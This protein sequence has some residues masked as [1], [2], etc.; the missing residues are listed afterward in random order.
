ML[1]RWYPVTYMLILAGLLMTPAIVNAE[2]AQDFRQQ[3][4]L[5]VYDPPVWF[6]EGYFIA[7]EK[8]PG[9]VFGP[10]QDFVRTLKGTTTW[11]I[12]DLEL[13]RL[14]QAS[15]DGKKV[16]YTVFLEAVSPEGT[17]Y[18]VFVALPH[19]SAQAW[20]DAR[21]AFH[22]GKAVGY[23]GETRKKLE[24]A[25]SQGFKIKAELRFLIE[26]GYTSLE[27]PENVI[28]SR[29]KFQPVFDLGAGHRISPAE[30]TK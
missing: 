10:V 3:N 18:W 8:N 12:E 11:L 21:R 17:D 2:S 7:S 20:F 4:G 25:L 14:E 28:M 27:V 23:Y 29:Y 19:E 30:K 26:K 9:Y 22:G 6:V 5:Q 13:K 16:E 15:V 24:V 1:K